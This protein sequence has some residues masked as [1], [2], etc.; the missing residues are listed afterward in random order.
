MPIAGSP[1]SLLGLPRGC[2]FAP[3]CPYA[4]PRHHELDPPLEP[5]P[6]VPGHAVACLLEPAERRRLWAEL[7][8]GRTPQQ[9]RAAA[10][11]GE[12]A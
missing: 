10:P 5:V 9:A 2:S 7:R 1:P 11:A 6:G 12:D 3:R 8:A 4:R